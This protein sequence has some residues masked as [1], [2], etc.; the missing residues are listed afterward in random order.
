VDGASEDVA[1][2]GGGA[3]TGPLA[4]A[5]RALLHDSGPGDP[6]PGA[7][8]AV[9]SPAGTETAAGGCAQVFDEVGPLRQP[10]PMHLDARIDLGSVSK[11]VGT[12]TAL[13]TLV[14]R[15]ELRLDLRLDA[16]LPELRGRPASS[17]TIADLLSHRAGLWE[18]WPL[19]LTASDAAAALDQAS[20][21][22]LRYAPGSGRHYSDLGFQL[23]GAVVARRSGTDLPAAV[24]ALAL[25]PWGLGHTRYA[26][27]VAGGPVAATSHGDRIEREMVA[28]GR[29]YPVTADA[30]TFHRWRTRV[31]VGEV[32]DGNAFHAYGG[33][34]GHAGL[35]STVGDL[36]DYGQIL[37]DSLNGSGPVGAATL[38]LFLQ[39]GPDPAQ[40]LG[41]RIWSR[42]TSEAAGTAWGHTGFP[43]VGLAVFPAV[44]AVVVLSTNRLHVPGT[45]R[46]T[47]DMFTAALAAAQA[48]L[49]PTARTNQGKSR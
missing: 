22:P 48:H 41:F 29:P 42:P 17:A 13:M 26:V 33:A 7:V 38:R 5:V 8:L 36:L 14:D 12:T 35:F 45:P 2:D 49:C 31:L 43:G 9:R 15:G 44:R 23:L 40:A 1:G 4:D 3:A 34:A 11:I 28:T 6:P 21:L 19:Y 25:R 27:P 24:A 39:P 32:N 37:L 46:A 20:A 10:V 30:A 16:V 18:W 47:E